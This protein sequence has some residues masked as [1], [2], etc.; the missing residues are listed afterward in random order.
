MSLRVLM[1]PMHTFRIIY[2]CILAVEVTASVLSR[3]RRGGTLVV[4]VHK[5]VSDQ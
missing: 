4:M 3:L 5:L 1:N 2:V